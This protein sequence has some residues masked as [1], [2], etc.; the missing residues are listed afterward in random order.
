MSLSSARTSLRL[1]GRLSG[2]QPSPQLMGVLVL[3]L[4]MGIVPH[5]VREYWIFL[6]TAGF[7]TAITVMGLAVIVGWAGQVTLAG[8]ALLGTSVYITGYLL[9]EG[10]AGSAPWPFIPAMI[11]GVACATVLSAL[12]AIPT[13]R[14]SGIYVMVLTM[15]LQVTMERTLF[16]YTWITGGA[17]ADVRVPRPE[18]FGFR[19][20]TDT[21]YFYLCFVAMVVSGL[22]IHA[23]RSSR[24]GR[25]IHLVRTDRQAAAAVGISPWRYRV[26]AFAVG[27]F[28][29]GIAGAFTAPLYESPPALTQ[30]ILFQ[31]LFLLA[32][33]VVAGTQTIVGL[34]SVAVAFQ[35]LPAALQSH[36]LSVY[37]LGG[38]GLIGGTLLGPRGMAGTLLDL[39][40][41]K[42]D[43]ARL[44]E[45]AGTEDETEA[46]PE[47]AESE[48]SP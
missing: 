47:P 48:G 4:V 17:G 45:A 26:I 36:R 37:L 21:R 27:G 28:L 5:F 12:V 46:P 3:A 42:R 15:G 30:Y 13:A 39:L 6:S 14:F 18:V 7:L 11:G 24:H 22:S 33:P 44:R 2:L 25:A 8:A 38:A 41:Q 16:T 43:V 40:Q 9:R 31:S 10:L 34:A 20:D 35:I 19:F 1:P 29:I 23:L 32:I